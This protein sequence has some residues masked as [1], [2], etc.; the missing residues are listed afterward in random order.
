MS[1]QL[2]SLNGFNRVTPNVNGFNRATYVNESNQN[3]NGF[4]LQG[5]I[6]NGIAEMTDGEFQM[7]LRAAEGGQ[8]MNGLRKMFKR[9]KERRQQ[10]R[11][12]REARKY[13][14]Q[15]RKSARRAAKAERKDLRND[16]L[17]SRIEA[18]RSRAGRPGFM[19][20]IQR[21]AGDFVGSVG[22][23]S[24]S[25]ITDDVSDITGMDFSGMDERGLFNRENAFQKWWR[26]S[27]TWQKVA[28]GAGGV[29]LL[30]LLLMDGNLVINKVT[31]R[32]PK[33]KKR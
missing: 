9:I 20:N 18:I 28:A 21:M 8:N 5:F 25:E 10:K 17:R 13:D 24:F 19:E 12:A 33:R 29:A 22:G 3:M 26:K 1:H 30:D 32:K 31:G 14:R 7:F 23:G 4:V 2:I 15:S 6:L 27:P 11:S 16:R